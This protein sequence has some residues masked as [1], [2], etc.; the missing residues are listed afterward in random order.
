MENNDFL[1]FNRLS[2]K[3]FMMN[4]LDKPKQ[5]SSSF[6]K[7]KKKNTLLQ[8]NLVNQLTLTTSTGYNLFLVLFFQK[9]FLLRTPHR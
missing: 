2:Y 4:A 6:A 3:L 5:E 8:I 9:Q 7:N 1:T